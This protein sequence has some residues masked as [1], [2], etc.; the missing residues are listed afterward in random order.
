MSSAWLTIHS[1]ATP[2]AGLLLLGVD[3]RPGQSLRDRLNGG[4]VAS[5]V[6][7]KGL[8]G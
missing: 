1:L 4:R 7:P 5:E 3:Y 6:T 2:R 8:Y